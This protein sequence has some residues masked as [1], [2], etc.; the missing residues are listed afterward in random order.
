[1]GR[2]P[3]PRCEVFLKDVLLGCSS[4][5]ST[6][7]LGDGVA[8]GFEDYFLTIPDR[9]SSSKVGVAFNPIEVLGVEAHDRMRRVI[10]LIGGIFG[11]LS[12]Q[13]ERLDSS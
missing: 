1:M 12:E 4:Q 3:I 11:E 5:H 10:D 7:Y 2:H 6:G 9:Q 13:R 8:G